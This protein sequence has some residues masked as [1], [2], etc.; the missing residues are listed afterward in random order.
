MHA[1]GIVTLHPRNRGIE[2]SVDNSLNCL[3]GTEI[4]YR[5]YD[6]EA[7]LN[8]RL[9]RDDY[10]I[11]HLGD[12][13]M[14]V[15]GVVLTVVFFLAGPLQSHHHSDLPGIGTFNYSGPPIVDVQ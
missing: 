5:T 7:A 9:S 6:A 11:S 10:R 12:R 8:G 2:K 3:A 14:R 13:P 1:T 4:D 15:F